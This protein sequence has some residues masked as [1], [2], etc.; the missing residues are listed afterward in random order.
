MTSNICARYSSFLFILKYYHKQRDN[1]F[2]IIKIMRC[3][4][5]LVYFIYFI[6]FMS[7]I[8]VVYVNDDNY[9]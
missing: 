5:E 3:S 2:E 9:L 1:E 4:R 7:I 8:I 6:C